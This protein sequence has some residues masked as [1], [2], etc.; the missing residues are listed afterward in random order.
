MSVGFRERLD[1]QSLELLAHAF[2]RSPVPQFVLSLS[3]EAYGRFAA[4]SDTFGDLLGYTGAELAAGTLG[5]ILH[6]ES[7]RSSVTAC[8]SGWR[9]PTGTRR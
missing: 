7:R 6:P 4:V 2:T 3:P 9:A 5:A 8:S 1:S